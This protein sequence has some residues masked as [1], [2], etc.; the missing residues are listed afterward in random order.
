MTY[1]VSP[2]CVSCVVEG[3]VAILDLRTNTYFSLNPVGASIWDHMSKPASLEDLVKAVSEEYA[4]APEECR[5][6]IT[7]LLDDMLKHGLIQ[8][9]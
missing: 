9:T 8:A 4:V 1:F 3:G 7:H 2:E 5:S 6:D